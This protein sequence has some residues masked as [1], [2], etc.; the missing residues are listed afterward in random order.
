MTSK[1]GLKFLPPSMSIKEAVI[2][3]QK[4]AKVNM[5]IGSMKSEFGHSLVGDSLVSL[6]SLSESV[7]STRIEGTQVTFYDMFEKTSNKQKE[8]EKQEVL[9]YQEALK[10]GLLL[11]ENGMP[12]STR[13]IKELHKILMINARGTNSAGGEFRKIQNFIGPDSKIEHAVYIPVEAQTISEYMEN[14]EFFVNGVHHS[15]FTQIDDNDLFTIDENAD[16]LLKIAIMHA[17]FE[18]IH[19]FLDGNGRLGRILIALMAVKYGL[20]NVPVFLVSEELE[21]E[22]SRYYDLLNGIRGEDPDW[23]AWLSFFIDCCGRMSDQLVKKMQTSSQLAEQGLKKIKLDSERKAWLLSFQCPRLT[24]KDVV[25]ACKMNISTARKA[26]NALVEY[27]LLFT[28]KNIK[29]NKAYINYNLI[30]LLSN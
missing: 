4:L 20:V 6:F 25:Q 18:S 24:V 26:L 3:L 27:D 5:I 28:S 8:W 19:P 17:Q 10:H 16:P 9:N 11:I 15:S 21:K 23:F 1:K 29:R 14:L 22:R 7:Q 13:L 30:R 2:L 12:F